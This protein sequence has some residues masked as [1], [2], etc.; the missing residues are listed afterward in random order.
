MVAQK[1]VTGKIGGGAVIYSQSGA[2]LSSTGLSSHAGRDSKT[3]FH[4]M[5]P[6]TGPADA[7][8]GL[9]DRHGNLLDSHGSPAGKAAANS[10]LGAGMMPT[11]AGAHG[12]AF[13]RPPPLPL[14]PKTIGDIHG[15]DAAQLSPSSRVKRAPAVTGKITGAEYDSRAGAAYEPPPAH[16]GSSPMMSGEHAALKREYVYSLRQVIR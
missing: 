16:P 7:V 14:A 9:Y 10:G 13:A 1:E 3:T 5:V 11:E 15:A 4:N 2:P 8:H 6:T 12:D